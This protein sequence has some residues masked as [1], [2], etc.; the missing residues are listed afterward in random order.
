VKL[1]GSECKEDNTCSGEE[2]KDVLGV[3]VAGYI[4]ERI[5]HQQ[6]IVDLLQDNEENG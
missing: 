6:S 5:A 4:L 3:T 2:C 1:Q